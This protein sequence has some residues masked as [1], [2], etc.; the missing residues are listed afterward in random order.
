MACSRAAITSSSEAA[1]FRNV[2]VTVARWS[3]TVN[4]SEWFLGFSWLPILAVRN[5]ANGHPAIAN[6]H[7]QGELLRRAFLSNHLQKLALGGDVGRPTFRFDGFGQV[8]ECER[9]VDRHARLADDSGELLLGVSMGLAEPGQSLG[10]F[11]SPEVLALQVLDEGELLLVAV[12]DDGLEV[13]HPRLLSGA[14]AAFSGDEEVSPGILRGFDEHGL[15]KPMGFDGLREFLELGQ[16]EV[17]PRLVRIGLDV[18]HGQVDGVA[19]AGPHD[20]VNGVVV[21]SRG[22]LG[23]VTHPPESFKFGL[24]VGHRFRL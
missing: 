17:L 4:R 7:P 22:T 19:G 21:E 20:A 18:L 24:F 2:T 14:E 16:V 12:G 6:G 15:K 8:E 13:G 23:T 5:V 3:L 9:L 11:D 10:F 1:D